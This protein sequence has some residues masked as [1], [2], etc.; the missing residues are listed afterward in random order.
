MNKTKGFTL[1][2]LLVVIAIIGILAALVLPRFNNARLNAQAGAGEA[3]LAS[4][5]TTIES[6]FLDNGSYNGGSG[7]TC[8]ATITT[9]T[10]SLSTNNYTNVECNAS[11]TA[12][13]FFGTQPDG[14]TIYCVDS[15][16]FAG[17]ATP[18]TGDTA[19]S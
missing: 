2:E 17:V 10:N 4:A 11:G 14:S 8:A 13:A 5:R 15:T 7:T 19:C 16:G 6:Y 3:S 9:F 12:Y 1:I 18:S